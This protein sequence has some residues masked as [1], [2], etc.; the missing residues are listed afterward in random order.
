MK[1]ILLLAL[2]LV[3]PGIHAQN[4]P[5]PLPC[6]AKGV[7]SGVD[8]Y[9]V[10]TPNLLYV[11]CDSTNLV[12]FTTTGKLYIV[13]GATRT[14]VEG[15]VVSVRAFD[16]GDPWIRIDF[17]QSGNGAVLEKGKDYQLDLAPDQTATI[18]I[19]ANSKEPGQEKVVR[20]AL[21]VAGPFQTL[22]ISFSTKPTAVIKAGSVSSLG[23]TFEVY[24]NVAL[25]QFP[26]SKVRFSEV[27]AL[28]AKIYHLAEAKLIGQTVHCP[29]PALCAAP[30]PAGG[31]PE[32]YGRVQVEL[33]TDH[34]RQPKAT[35]AVEGLQNLFGDNIKAQSDVMMGAVPKTKDD[36]LYYLKFDHQ[37]GPGSKPGYAVEAKIAPDLGPP[38]FWGFVLQP[39][40]NM[41]IGSGTVSN[42]KVN[43]TIIPSLGMTSIYRF[44]STALEAIRITP[45]V[46]FETN[47]EFNKRNIIYDQDF[48][49][50]V[51]FLDSSRLVRA[52]QKY[53]E[54]QGK[55]GNEDLKFSNDFA[56]WG[57]GLKL[58]LG[59]ELGGAL[60]SQTVKASKS[61]ATVMVP[62]YT[63]ARIRPKLSGYVEYKRIN[64]TLS[65]LPR[66]LFA[67]EYSTR[68]SSDGTTIRLAP[69][70]LSPVG[71]KSRE[72]AKRNI[73]TQPDITMWNTR[74]RKVIE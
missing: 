28:K 36:S 65:V 34:L 72:E 53:K 2:L 35:V 42:V 47:K 26:L 68:Q 57:A 55:P 51:G 30:D 14:S 15:A 27:T 18:R 48:Q 41:D 3:A 8:A 29:P 6:E 37:A 19:M 31:N 59:S 74:S 58:F 7:A 11:N 70:G 62:T 16:S 20:R 4:A 44:N 40:L 56:N 63:V 52:W 61:S 5:T 39:A 45:A 1:A 13:T 73:I 46:S 54:L 9:R 32:T 67:T 24:S 64:L 17:S 10:V 38:M 69:L 66:Y 25:D 23:S 43:D 22:T 12:E 49:F 71:A 60:D 33:K 21:P 50:F